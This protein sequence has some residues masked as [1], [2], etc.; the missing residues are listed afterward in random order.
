MSDP[1]TRVAFQYLSQQT[2]RLEATL[3]PTWDQTLIFDLIELYGTP[4][5]IERH[6]PPVMVELFDYDQFGADEFL[7]RCQASLVTISFSHYNSL[8]RKSSCRKFELE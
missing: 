1:Y 6:P 8:L 5:L 2:E 7:G 4:A 3:C